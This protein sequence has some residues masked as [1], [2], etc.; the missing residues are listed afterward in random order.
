M[1]GGGGSSVEA[2]G[3]WERRLSDDVAPA[4]AIGVPDADGRSKRCSVDLSDVTARTELLG[5]MARLKMKAGSTPR[6]YSAR[7]V[8]LA[9]EKT[10]IRVPV[11][12][13]VAV[14]VPSALRS[15]ARRGEVCAGIIETLPESSSTSWTL[16]GDLPGNATIFEPRHERPSGLSAVSKTDV[17][18]GGEEKA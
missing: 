10:R 16:P 12:E 11:S 2:E 5:E 13:A 7:R 14:R 15:M 1:L 4:A 17:F 6:R 8:Q 3:D 18:V 9:V